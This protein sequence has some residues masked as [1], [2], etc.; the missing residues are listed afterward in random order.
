MAEELTEQTRRMAE[1][2]ALWNEELKAIRLLLEAMAQQRREPPPPTCQANV[3]QA[4]DD[5]QPVA[6]PRE[7][8]PEGDDPVLDSILAQFE[9]LQKDLTR[10]R[11]S[12]PEAG[13]GAA[14]VRLSVP[15]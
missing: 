5:A 7:P 8:V 3:S 2:R 4:P 12:S 15:S 1:E 10:R 6:S 14:E 13:P 9:I 11:K